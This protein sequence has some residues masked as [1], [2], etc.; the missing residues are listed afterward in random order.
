MRSGTPVVLVCLCAE[1]VWFCLW[2]GTC[3][4]TCSFWLKPFRLKASP[5]LSLKSF[6]SPE[7]LI[8]HLKRNVDGAKFSFPL[9]ACGGSAF[10][11]NKYKKSVAVNSQ[12]FT[13]IWFSN[14]YVRPIDINA[15]CAKQIPHKNLMPEMQCERCKSLCLFLVRIAV[16]C[17]YPHAP[18]DRHVPIY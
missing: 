11:I 1:V 14:A 3:I 10:F 12:R 8:L 16:C 17:V 2:V 13:L 5:S 18:R 6:T 4:L 7:I 9:C 15:P